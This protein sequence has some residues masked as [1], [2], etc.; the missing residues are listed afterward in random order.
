[1][2]MI[3]DPPSLSPRD[4][5]D[6]AGGRGGEEEEYDTM[7]ARAP[8]VQAFDMR[9]GHQNTARVSQACDTERAVEVTGRDHDGSGECPSGEPPSGLEP[10]G[11]TR[12]RTSPAEALDL[13]GPGGDYCS[14][15][16]RSDSVEVGTNEA[17][18]MWRRWVS[19]LYPEKEGVE[20]E[21][22]DMNGR[23]VCAQDGL[24]VTIE[25]ADSR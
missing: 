18:D 20:D 17:K 21:G 12:G 5:R 22:R 1:M 13:D 24:E 2:R 7:C 9:A 3:V 4:R 6:Q 16:L 8:R 15:P 10:N 11:T 19:G 23:K 25:T 14:G